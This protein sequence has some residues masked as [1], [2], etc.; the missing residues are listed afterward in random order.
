[1]FYELSKLK[2]S[3]LYN[4]NEVTKAFPYKK[5]GFSTVK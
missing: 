2:V 3:P 4:A 1:M 5:A